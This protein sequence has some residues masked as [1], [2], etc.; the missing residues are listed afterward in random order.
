MS[1]SYSEGVGFVTE[2]T[3]GNVHYGPLHTNVWN[4]AGFAENLSVFESPG[5]GMSLV[6][7][8]VSHQTGKVYIGK[9]DH[10]KVGRRAIL[11]IRCHI[12]GKIKNKCPAIGRACMKY[13]FSWFVVDRCT[14][15][16]IAEREAWW[17]N[18]YNSLV[19]NGYN[20]DSGGTSQGFH[21]Q[22]VKKMKASWKDP[23]RK[24]ERSE[25]I[26]LGLNTE[27]A[28][29]NRLASRKR[30]R[31]VLDAKRK[32]QFEDAAT[33]E[34]ESALLQK[35]LENDSA[36]SK[37]KRRRNGEFIPTP[38]ERKHERLRLKAE[39]K[40]ARRLLATQRLKETCTKRRE[41]RL[42]LCSPEEAEKIL[43]N[44]RSNENKYN[45]IS[46]KAEGLLARRQMVIAKR[47]EQA[48]TMSTAERASFAKL[49]AKYDRANDSKSKKHQALLT[50]C[51]PEEVKEI[52]KSQRGKY[53]TK[54]EG[55]L[56]RKQVV[57]AKRKERAKTMS[58]SKR[59]SFWKTCARRDRGA[60]KRKEQKTS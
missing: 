27:T 9:T 48:K 21:P 8:G 22:T 10:G 18:E 2:P 29:L 3:S 37:R 28:K 12:S 49:C 36:V 41:A 42:V 47:K 32:Q 60:K 50:T 44:R 24:K 58:T 52:R 4:F 7:A 1:G 16:E 54:E 40:P 53:S 43:K 26:R 5:I 39:G 34:E 15:P 56:A 13:R 45:G 57:I 30:Q 17:I 6:Y 31:L 11:R 59:A 20:I 38:S 55:I 25:K 19:P 23:V 46:T 51:S 35:F 33:K 14:Q